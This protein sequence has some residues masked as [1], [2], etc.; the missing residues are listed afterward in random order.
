MCWRNWS[1]CWPLVFA[2]AVE[3]AEVVASCSRGDYSKR[4][5]TA[6][7][8]GFLLELCNGINALC[9]ASENGLTD[10]QRVLDEIGDGCLTAR[11]AEGYEGRFA[12]LGDAATSARGAARRATWCRS[13]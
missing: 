12:E 9:E 2:F 11:M 10:L 4:L 7:R 1:A 13:R 5:S 3:V 8:D 6:G